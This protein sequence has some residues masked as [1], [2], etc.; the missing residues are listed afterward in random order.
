MELYLQLPR[1]DTVQGVL[2][3]LNRHGKISKN[4]FAKAYLDNHIYSQ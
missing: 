3:I 2:D 1:E 4:I